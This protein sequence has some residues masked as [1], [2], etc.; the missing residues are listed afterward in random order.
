MDPKSRIYIPLTLKEMIDG[1]Q[2]IIQESGGKLTGEE[3]V[4]DT[5]YISS[6]D[7]PEVPPGSVALFLQRGT[8]KANEFETGVVVL[9]PSR[10]T[11]RLM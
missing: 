8:T 4:V 5:T 1:L 3:Y 6:E 7:N 10:L 11:E 9:T 2:G